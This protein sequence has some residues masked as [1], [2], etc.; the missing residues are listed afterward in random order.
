MSDQKVMSK[1]PTLERLALDRIRDQFPPFQKRGFRKTL[2]AA[3]PDVMWQPAI[4]PLLQV[5]LSQCPLRNREN[6]NG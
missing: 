2:R 5:R 3:F 4:S 1:L 6:L